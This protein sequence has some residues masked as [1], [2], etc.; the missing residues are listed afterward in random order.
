MP[1]VIELNQSNWD[2]EVGRSDVPMVVAAASL[3]IIGY[4][5]LGALLQLLV[6]DLPTG[7]GLSGLMVSPAFGFAG[8]GFPILAMNA[9][10]IAWGAA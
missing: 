6:L 8:V 7:L 10:S 2:K 4:L 5:A 3:M 9:F 1:N